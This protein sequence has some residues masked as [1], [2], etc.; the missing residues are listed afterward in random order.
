MGIK[1]M[2]NRY[3]VHTIGH[4]NHPISHFIELLQSHNINC[5]IDVR[6]MPYSQYNPQYNKEVLRDSL[7][8]EEILYAH[9]GKEFGARHTKPSLLDNQGRVDFKK[10]RVG[11]DFLKGVQRLEDAL[12]R[13]YKIALM[14][15][16]KDPLTCHRFSMVSYHLDRIGYEVYHILEDCGV[17]SN[18]ELEGEMLKK[19]K[20][21]IPQDTL[22]ER[23]TRE[24]QIEFGYQL[25]N[26]DIAFHWDSST[27]ELNEEDKSI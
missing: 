19:Y 18:K 22:F 13:G 17:I 16:E 24:Q 23:V 6:S 12:D 26:Q 25:C 7:F 11:E 14:C 9:F 10:V 1:N 27:S 15:S 8:H 21:K 3:I 20:K 4:S 2:M 5:I